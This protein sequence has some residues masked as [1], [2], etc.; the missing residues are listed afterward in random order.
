MMRVI[1]FRG[2]HADEHGKT[3]IKLDGKE[4]R[5]L[6]LVGDLKQYDGLCWIEE[7]AVIP[8]TVGQFTGLNDSNNKEIWEGDIIKYGNTIHKVVFE[9]R[10]KTAYFGLVYSDIKTLP[11][12]HYQDLK[13]IEIIGNIFENP[14][15]VEVAE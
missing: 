5:G 15:L 3:V 14:N 12:G 2:F 6:W 4:I 10:N 7:H 8:E 11:F 13:Q 9:T 1:K